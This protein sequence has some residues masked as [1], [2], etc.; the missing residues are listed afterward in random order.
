MVEIN[1]SDN[2]RDKGCRGK[3]REYLKLINGNGEGNLLITIAREHPHLETNNRNV[4]VWSRFQIKNGNIITKYDLQFFTSFAMLETD[5]I[6]FWNFLFKVRIWWRN[7]SNISL[8][9]LSCTV[10]SN[11]TVRQYIYTYSN[12]SIDIGMR[13][14]D[15]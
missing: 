8:S 15:L 11:I 7:Y 5:S 3:T 4:K 1:G 13:Q 2:R 10:S 12:D 14:N 9:C 6:F